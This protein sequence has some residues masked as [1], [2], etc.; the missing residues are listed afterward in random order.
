M[1]LGAIPNANNAG[2]P[3]DPPTMNCRYVYRPPFDVPDK[4]RKFGNLT[5]TYATQIHACIVEI[6][7]ETGVTEVVDYAAVDDCGVRINPQIV[8]G[9]VMGATAHAIGAALW[10]SFVYDEDGNL[11]TPNFYDYHVPHT[12]DMP[13]LKTGAI[14][15]PSPFT[16]LG[17]KGMGEGGG[18]GIH[19]ICAGIQD[20]LRAAGGAI[21]TDSHNPYHR[22]W[23]ML[24]HP[25]RDLH[26]RLPVTLVPDLEP[27]HT[28]HQPRHLSRIVDHTPDH[29]P[30]SVEL[31]RPVHVHLKPP[32]CDR[33]AGTPAR[34]PRRY[35]E[36][37]AQTEP[38][39]FRISAT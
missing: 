1:A 5:L 20:A 33:P 2:F 30:R 4:E 29:L 35:R 39:S 9:Q 26:L 36:R 24:S 19:C 11:L 23:E 22:V 27:L 12:L 32:G 16:P 13:P 21:V 18:G 37:R 7:P 10:E 15:S 14:E 8:E 3:D 25:E 6:D 34:R 17:T 38:C 31:L 28:R